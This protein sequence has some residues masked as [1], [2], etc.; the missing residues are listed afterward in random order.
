MEGVDL[1]G[2]LPRVGTEAV[3]TA[4]AVQAT[5]DGERASDA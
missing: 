3:V 5:P 2:T 1:E 4:W